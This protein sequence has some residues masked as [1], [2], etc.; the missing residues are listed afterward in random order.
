MKLGISS[1]TF[2]WAVGVKGY[3]PA[4]AMDELALLDFAA[5]HEIALL[6]IGDNLPLHTFSPSRLKQFGRTAHRLGIELEVGARPLVRER[7]V[8]YIRIARE[9]DARLIRFVIADADFHPEPAET[10]AV[11]RSLVPDL[12][13][14]TLGIENHDTLPATR[15][16]AI[17]DEVGSDRVGVCLDTANSLGAGEGIEAVAETLAPVTVNLHIKDFWIERIPSLMGFSVSGRPVGQGMLNLDFVLD[18][19]DRSGRCRTAILELWPPQQ[20]DLERI[21]EKEARWA[22]ESLEYLK[23]LF[24]DRYE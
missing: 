13:G 9:L 14:L 2:G 5:R 22:R 15:L 6:Q 1:Y 12:D 24:R 21:I 4:K 3:E 19:L 18:Q 20:T 16:R 17:I 23:P 10:V 8:E 7:A 11:L